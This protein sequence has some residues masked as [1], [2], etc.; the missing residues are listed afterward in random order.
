MNNLIQ[1][2]IRKVLCAMLTISFIGFV[3]NQAQAREKLNELVPETKAISLLK[4]FQIDDVHKSHNETRIS[5]MLFY[6][7]VE[8]I[9]HSKEKGF[10]LKVT[11][12]GLSVKKL[13]PEFKKLPELSIE[14][15]FFHKSGIEIQTKYH[16]KEV[17]LNIDHKRKFVSIAG[18]KHLRVKDFYSE[19]R[20]TDL[21]KDIYFRKLQYHLGESVEIEGTVGRKN[22]TI[23]EDLHNHHFV[24]KG[25]DLHLWDLV[26]GFNNNAFLKK[27]V[28]NEVTV[29][30]QKIGINSRFGKKH[31]SAS[32]GNFHG[33]LKFS[34]KAAP[35]SDITI[36]DIM[37]NLKNNKK[38][39]TFKLS[40]IDFKGKKLS[41]QGL[42][43]KKR[44]E[45]S[46]DKNNKKVN[47]INN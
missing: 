10:E 5:G 6:K 28:L 4:E 25:K 29:A 26:P 13:F 36:S 8:L 37:P 27:L 11:G 22:V 14:R 43:G 40:S 32:F 23:L 39:E 20:K 21:L 12:S 2:T 16:G 24:L 41:I 42:L 7:S 45:L 3:Q 35:H 19:F 33:E 38:L 18:S 34:L 44:V 47:I 15:L 46:L 30:R 31:L 1:D 17:K 9:S